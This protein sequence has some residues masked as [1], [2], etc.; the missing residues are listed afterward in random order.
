MSV[1]NGLSRVNEQK[2]LS[3][4][5]PYVFEFFC[6]ILCLKFEKNV[7]ENNRVAIK[8]MLEKQNPQK[9][10]KKKQRGG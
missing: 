7:S 9:T 3:F 2:T 1:E 4:F 6:F 10:K 5:P 8:I